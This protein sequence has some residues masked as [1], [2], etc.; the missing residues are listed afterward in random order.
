M[1]AKVARW[2]DALGER[3]D[4]GIRDAVVALNLTGIPTEASCEG[5]LD[6]GKPGPWVEIG[7]PRRP[8]VSRYES[9]IKYTL[10]R[11]LPSAVRTTALNLIA[12]PRD[13]KAVARAEQAL[14]EFYATREH[15]EYA[16][17][18]WPSLQGGAR[19][20]SHSLRWTPAEVQAEPQ[21][22]RE[23]LE[24]SRE[25]MRAFTKFLVARL[26]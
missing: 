10:Y 22:Q 21:W 7:V 5:H 4:L 18:L 23:H 11:R 25:E 13:R 12:H 24:R 2:T 9:Q 15:G 8:F 14:N 16:L 1:S 26:P 3:V 20:L 19:L 6:H 17:E